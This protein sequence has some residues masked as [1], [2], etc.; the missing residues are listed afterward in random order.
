[1]K[2]NKNKTKQHNLVLHYYHNLSCIYQYKINKNIYNGK[3]QII[4][5]LLILI[6]L[7]LKVT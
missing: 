1:M 3:N 2:S 7:I 6:H 4:L 5:I